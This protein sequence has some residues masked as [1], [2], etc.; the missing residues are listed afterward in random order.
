MLCR[1][2]LH[3]SEKKKV[4]LQY[5]CILFSPK[6]V[7]CMAVKSTDMGGIVPGGVSQQTVA[8]CLSLLVSFID[9][10]ISMKS[11]L[12]FFDTVSFNTGQPQTHAA[13]EDDPELLVLLPPLLSPRIADITTTHGF[14]WCQGSELRA[15]SV[16]CKHSP[17]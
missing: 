11:L 6:Y 13:E 12:F 4:C 1:Q 9:I 15:L 3:H 17:N 2:L 7:Q 14:M 5:K 16:L 10:Y 8:V